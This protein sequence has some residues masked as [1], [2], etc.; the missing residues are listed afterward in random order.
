MSLHSL[1]DAMQISCLDIRNKILREECKKSLL[2]KEF[3]AV[4][5]ILK[6]TTK[7][8]II[9]RKF[10][11]DVLENSKAQWMGGLVKWKTKLSSSMNFSLKLKA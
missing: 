2:S 8:P 3:Y 5:M 6:E 7:L 4:L 11:K 10:L 1:L 9:S